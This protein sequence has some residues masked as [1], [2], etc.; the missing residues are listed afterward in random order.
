VARRRF[1]FCLS[2][3]LLLLLLP[4]SMAGMRKHI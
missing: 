4:A 2:L 3:L 1:P